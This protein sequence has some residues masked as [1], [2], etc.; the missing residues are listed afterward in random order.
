MKK[1]IVILTIIIAII[2]LAIGA[3]FIII[4]DKAASP[5][6]I[7]NK[8]IS[9]INEKNYDG[10]YQLLDSTS[11]KSISNEDFVT[12]NKNIYE[13][14]DLTNITI[15]VQNVKKVNDSKTDISYNTKMDTEAGE[16][17]FSNNAALVKENGEYKIDWS[18]NLIFP[19]LNNDDKVRVQTASAARGT[20]TDRNGTM[21]AG[22]GDVSSVGLVPGKMSDNKEAEIEKIAGLLD[23]STDSINNALNASYVK[24]DT[25]V[26]IK[27]VAKDSSTLKEQLLQIKGI[28]INTAA[29]RVYPFGEATSHLIGYVGSITADELEKNPDKGYNANSVIGKTG[30]EQAYED[31][32]KGT[33]GVEIYIQDSNGNK[34]STIAKKDGRDGENIKLTIDANIQNTIYN[35]SKNDKGLFVVMQPET[36]EIL[37][38]V[39][40]PSYNANDFILGIGTNEWNNL[41]NNTDKPMYNRFL[42][43]WCPRFKF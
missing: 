21:L 14:I 3:G 30:L 5:E 19:N 2:V 17:D 11:K 23:V 7:L 36:G 1:K 33:D 32:L 31:R 15:E 16:I 43:T 8:Y 27:K 41:T 10:M 42:Q 22:A 24:D 18:S 4:N 38:L 39:S 20:I 34:K 13:G 6:S 35:E 37:A 40:T 9:Y 28:Q 26:P 12:R 25:F 29:A